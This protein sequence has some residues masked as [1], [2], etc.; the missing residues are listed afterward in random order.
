M[1]KIIGV[2]Q[3]SLSLAKADPSIAWARF[4]LLLP[5]PGMSTSSPTSENSE[6]K[7]SIDIASLFQTDLDNYIFTII[8]LTEDYYQ[9]TLRELIRLYFT[10]M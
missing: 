2:T 3:L 9:K 5:G 4:T 7:L 6:S 10:F 8:T 1:N